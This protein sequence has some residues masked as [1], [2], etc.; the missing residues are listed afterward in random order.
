MGS[1][2][3]K[4]DYLTRKPEDFYPDIG[5]ELYTHFQITPELKKLRRRLKLYEKHQQL[6]LF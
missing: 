2:T 6:R 5:K 1:L 4:F 3:Q